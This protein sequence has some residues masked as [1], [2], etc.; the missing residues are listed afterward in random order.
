MGGSLHQGI[1]SQ[2]SFPH[3]AARV[4][5]DAVRWGPNLQHVSLDGVRLKQEQIPRKLTG[6][7]TGKI[8]L[9]NS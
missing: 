7:K 1:V 3:D 8:Y 6:D 4:N 2:V 5:L 9:A